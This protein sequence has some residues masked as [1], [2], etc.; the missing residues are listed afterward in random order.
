MNLV[1]RNQANDAGK[2]DDLGVILAEV[3][4]NG[5][6][7]L[8]GGQEDGCIFHRTPPPKNLRMI[9]AGLDGETKRGGRAK[10]LLY[11]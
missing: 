1:F 3:R 4:Y 8:T 2:E 5:L 7:R 6:D 10:G 9:P 11:S